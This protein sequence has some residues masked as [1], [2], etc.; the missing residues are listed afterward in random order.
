[1]ENS[2]QNLNQQSRSR[3]ST[4]QRKRGRK[5]FSAGNFTDCDSPF[6]QYIAEK[7]K[8]RRSLL[9]A[10]CCK[11]LLIS[12]EGVQLGHPREEIVDLLH[13]ISRKGWS[14][15]QAFHQFLENEVPLLK[16]EM[17]HSD[18][19]EVILFSSSNGQKKL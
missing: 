4:R 2:S 8:L 13:L 10:K 19:S 1:M 16:I 3:T 17:P 5:T 7:R 14:H 18:Q 6:C 11:T 12:R 9:Y 15:H